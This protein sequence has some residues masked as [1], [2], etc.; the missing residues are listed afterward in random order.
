MSSKNDKESQEKVEVEVK[1][2]EKGMLLSF[3]QRNGIH[4]NTVGQ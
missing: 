1:A 3:S 2:K 4:L